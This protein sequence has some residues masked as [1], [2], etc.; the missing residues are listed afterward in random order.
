MKKNSF[1]DRLVPLASP[2]A[3]ILLGLLLVVNPDSASILIA[4]IVGWILTIV[5]IGFGVAAIV[6]RNRAIRKGIIAVLFV[7]VGGTLTANPLVLAAFIGRIIGLLIAVRGIRDLLL[8]SSYGYSRILAL[9]TTVV[10]AILVV[11]P[12]TTSRLVFSL[13]GL[14]VLFIGIGMLL[15]RLKQRKRLSGG[16]SNIIDAL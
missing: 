11:L 13:C 2:V 7:C 14:V 5:G 3:V 12:M 6:D 8:H 15:D 1:V 4:R 9:I 16:D 10:G